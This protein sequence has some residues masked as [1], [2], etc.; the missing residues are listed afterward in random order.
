LKTGNADGENVVFV[1]NR[2]DVV[3]PL[4]GKPQPPRPLEGKPLAMDD[5]SDRRQALAEWLT[6][7]QNPYFT[8]SI[9]NRIWANFYGVG[10]VEAVD[11][12]RVTN[13]ASNEELLSGA[14]KSLADNKY[15]LKALMRLI[16]QSETYQRSSHSLRENTGDTRFYS[17][18]YP[19]RL[20]AEVLLDT[21]SQATG[22][23]TQFKGYPEGWRAIQLPDS[24]VDSYFLKSFGR[25]DRE[26]TCECERTAE[27]SVTQVL[28]ISNGDTLNKKLTAKGNR[29]EKLLAEKMP[30]EKI[31]EEIYLSALCRFP[32]DAEKQKMTKAFEG[33]E[34]K[35]RRQALEDIYWA[36]L[37]S[38]EFLFNH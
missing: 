8:R 4:R 18:Y 35:E 38:R 36:V 32:T 15:D 24:N 27:P 12:L 37:S 34:E 5:E 10:L 9:V 29:L 13:P 3:Q 1:A 22:A 20:M 6:S 21:L 16:L 14:A 28:H 31:V 7:A 26:K 23:P 11:D 2:G 33:A 25:P 17:R 19:R 30:S